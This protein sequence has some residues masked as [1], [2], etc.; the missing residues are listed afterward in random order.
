MGTIDTAS[1]ITLAG[2]IVKHFRGRIERVRSDAVEGWVD[3]PE[4]E[5]CAV[6]LHV[7][8]RPVSEAELPGGA[9][10]RATFRL[11]IPA[12]LRD[13]GVHKIA[14]RI[15]AANA[16]INTLP[17]IAT[18]RATET[19][20]ADVPESDVPAPVLAKN[21]VSSSDNPPPEAARSEIAET[22][23]A[24]PEAPRRAARRN[25][26]VPI[27]MPPDMRG[28]MDGQR[29]TYIYGWI[30]DTTRPGPVE[31]A[32]FVD[33][34]QVLV[35]P[36]DVFRADLMSAG[37]SSDGRNGFHLEIPEAFWD[38]QP[39]RVDVRLAADTSTA[40]FMP[41]LVSVPPRPVKA[42]P[43]AKKPRT[44]PR[45]EPKHYLVNVEKIVRGKARMLVR[46]WA[47][48][49][50]KSAIEG[51]VELRLDGAGDAV[52]IPSL[53]HR[54]DLDKAG[55]AGGMAAFAAVFPLKEGRA[56]PQRLRLKAASA[57]G[58]EDIPLADVAQ[59]TAA[60]LAEA[61]GRRG[62]ELNGWL[63]DL[64]SEDQ[65]ATVHVTI[66]DNAP[67][68]LPL[69]A[70]NPRCFD[71][72]GPMRAQFAISVSDLCHTL[73]ARDCGFALETS[74]KT[75]VK[76]SDPSGREAF[77]GEVALVAGVRFHLEAL[78]PS[79]IAG[80]LVHTEAKNRIAEMD[81]YVDGLP[82]ATIAADR[83]RG[84]L[85]AKEMT[86]QGGGFQFALQ[87]PSGESGEAEIR[88]APR[89]TRQFFPT[90]VTRLT[91]PAAETRLR[92]VYPLL[93]AA[94]DRGLSI[95]LPVYNAREEV[96]RCLDSLLEHSTLPCRV[97]VIDDCSPDADIAPMLARY[98]TCPHV[99]VHTNAVNLG[100]TATINRGVALAGEDDVIFLNSDTLAGPGWLQGLRAAAYHDPRVATV[101]AVSNN[102]G[103]FSVPE[104]SADNPIPQGFAFAD[105]SRLVRQ[106]GLGAYPRVPTGNGFCM[107]VRRDAIRAVGKL[108]DVAFPKGYGEENDFCM[109][110]ARAGFIHVVDDRTLIFH[111]RSASFQSAKKDLLAAGR[112]VVDARYPE[113][114]RLVKVFTEGGAM[115][116]MRWRVRRAVAG[117]ASVPQRPRP[118]VLF[119]ISTRTGG[120]PQTNRDL[121]RALSH[122]HEPWVLVCDSQKLE[123][124]VFRDGEEVAVENVAL[125]APIHPASHRSSSYDDAAAYLLL[126]Y[127]F[128]L[129]HIRHLGWHGA[130]LP[131]VCRTLGLPVVLSLH[132]YYTVCPS[133]KLLDE[134]KTYCAGKCTPTEGECS[135]E[136]WPQRQFPPLKNAFVHRWREVFAEAFRACDSLVT[137]SPGGREVFLNVFDEL[138]GADFRVIPHGRTFAATAQTAQAPDAAQP[139]KILIPGNISPAKGSGLINALL[140]LDVERKLEFHLL[141]DPGRVKRE[142][143]VVVHGAYAREDFV[144]K[145]AAI[146][147]HIGAILSNWPETYCHTLTEMW[148]AG[149]PVAGIDIGAVGER[150]AAHGGGWLLP[151]QATPEEIY[152]RLLDIAA[153]SEGWLA[154]TAAITT[155]QQGP[156]LTRGADHM[157]AEYAALYLQVQRR[158]Q[159]LLAARAVEPIRRVAVLGEGE[160]WLP[161]TGGAP[162][163]FWPCDWRTPL[164]EDEDLNLDA[165]V[166][167]DKD[168]PPGTNADFLA[169]AARRGVAVLL[170]TGH[171]TDGPEWWQRF[172]FEAIS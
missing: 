162:A 81:V 71:S 56:L 105:F 108:D 52:I 127:A 74:D 36:A 149:V 165:V 143:N 65:P 25:A 111:K 131:Q 13:G 153:D 128:E 8:G 2:D 156:N 160:G 139:L 58:I 88:F 41:V 55:I 96:E 10:G 14:V 119:V 166:L 22:P 7:D 91:L 64:D 151:L 77:S 100:Y 92:Q 164:L 76:L 82:L 1:L 44:S 147:P 109:R 145:V 72:A 129:V 62:R 20:P 93:R 134:A 21:A 37:V 35:A 142:P 69:M 95:I 48:R 90:T 23:L 39:H 16:F 167:K 140:A 103:A 68:A 27:V 169:K 97:I 87:N 102:S 150:I 51:P 113:Y 54:G 85:I 171:A 3:W 99:E 60:L 40:L 118:R 104:I 67:L 107:Y 136:L 144:D 133:V 43:A 15:P 24:A 30:A 11:D 161:E 53:L 117:L 46:G 45:L 26:G 80:W 172:G 125:D 152:H 66:E 6:E 124:Y 115:Q 137:T 106:V 146:A 38:D 168:L 170:H 83:T 12:A 32:L 75:R 79:R 19:R 114:N 141:G 116:A 33:N 130:D 138:K 63:V 50:D 94:G 17:V 132:D 159:R 154:Q 70:E 155:W 110:A 18:L 120:T 86:E 123:L 98:K 57:A 4:G 122:S 59:D 112:A 157:G 121:M 158:R 29:R 61:A 89:F 126:K 31:V 73:R 28:W 101:T 9:A 49:L 135:V 34:Q 163:V 47:A 148:A 42:K 84:D 78:T 5:V